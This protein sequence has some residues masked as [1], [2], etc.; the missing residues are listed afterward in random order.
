MIE[1]KWNDLIMVAG[2][3]IGAS[4]LVVALFSIG[5]RLFT[6]SVQVVAGKGKNKSSSAS[7]EIAFKLAS[8]VSFGLAAAVLTYGLYIMVTFSKLQK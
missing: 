2:A 7:K 6:N 8:F 1:I 4:A 5:V 3:S